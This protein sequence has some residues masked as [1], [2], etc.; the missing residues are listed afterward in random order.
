MVSYGNS[1]YF[2]SNRNLTPFW[3][4]LASWGV[5]SLKRSLITNHI[6]A[7]FCSTSLLASGG[8]TLSCPIA[9]TLHL[10]K[11]YMYRQTHTHIYLDVSVYVFPC[12]SQFSQLIANSKIISTLLTH[13]C[14]VWLALTCFQ[15]WS[16]TRLCP[17]TRIRT[18]CRMCATGAPSNWAIVQR[19]SVVQLIS[20]P[21]KLGW[22]TPKKWTKYIL[23]VKI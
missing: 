3:K 22:A 6:P 17:W 16:A 2:G 4:S 8:L 9:S 14:C 7:C 18:R 20:I 5:D 19:R 15:W 10:N 12:I 1:K 21:Y 13:L 11:Y 23:Y